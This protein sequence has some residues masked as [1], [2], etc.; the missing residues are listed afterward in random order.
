MAEE[1]DSGS[2]RSL[3]LPLVNPSRDIWAISFSLLC[4]LAAEPAGLMITLPVVFLVYIGMAEMEA[5]DKPW[6]I[7]Y[8]CTSVEA[9][10]TYA[11]LYCI[12]R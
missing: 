2:R 9:G 11:V 5:D 1:G 3:F 12:G 7:C 6:F 10:R 8:C 4:M